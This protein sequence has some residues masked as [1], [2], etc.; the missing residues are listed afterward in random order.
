MTRN[1]TWKYTFCP[2]IWERVRRWKD[3]K[4]HALGLESARLPNRDPVFSASSFLQVFH[5]A[6]RPS[7]STASTTT[8]KCL[9]PASSSALDVCAMMGVYLGLLFQQRRQDCLNISGVPHLFYL[10]SSGRTSEDFWCRVSSGL[11]LSISMV[12][13]HEKNFEI[14]GLGHPLLISETQYH[15]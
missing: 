10:W 9:F 5:N 1:I 11:S 15:P 12:G 2:G 4:D 13:H 3:N 8:L 7:N 6:R 14:E